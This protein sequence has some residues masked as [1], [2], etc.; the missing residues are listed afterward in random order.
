MI[1]LWRAVVVA[2]LGALV[3]FVGDPVV[4][5]VFRRAGGAPRASRPTVAAPRVD[6]AIDVA[7][8]ADLGDSGPL[9]PGPTEGSSPIEQAGAKLR[10]GRAIG[11]L[12]RIACYACILAG[13]PMGLA[14]IVAVKGLARYPDLKSS[15][16]TAERFIIGTLASMLV[17]AGGAGLA[18]WLV[19]LIR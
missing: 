2:G 5:F 4:R 8:G 15:D 10:A 17:A 6:P 1:D 19:G 3:T 12:E 11:W 16:G 13:F 9:A 14:A 18:L 7:V